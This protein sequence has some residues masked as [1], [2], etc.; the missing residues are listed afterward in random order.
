MS[1]FYRPDDGFVGD[2]IP[3]YWQGQYH[4][5]YLKDPLPPGRYGP[6]HILPWAHLV[7]SDLTQWE[8]WPLVIEPGGPDDPDSVGCYT[9]SV[10]ERNGIYYMFYTGSA[11]RGNPQTTCLATSR[12][13]RVWVK[14]PRNPIFGADPHWYEMIDWRD[15]FPF[16]NE[17]VG[18]YWMLHAAR[19]KSGPSN[20]RGCLALA[21]SPDLENWEV[22]PPF[23]APR[24]YYTHECP[25][26]FRWNDKWVLVY[27][28]FSE[29]HVTHY[30]MSDSLSGP[31]LAPANDTF[32]GRAFYAA[33]TASDG[34]R[35][36]VFG[37]DPTRKG[38]TD[39]GAW[40]WAGNMVIHEVVSGPEGGLAVKLPPEVASL[41]TQPHLIACTPKFGEW[42]VQGGAFVAKQNDGFS[43]CTLADLPDTGLV[44]L[45]L[46][47]QLGTRS[48]GVLLRAETELESYYQVRWEP[49][50]QRIVFDRWPRPGDVPFML[51]RPLPI[52]PATPLRLQILVEGSAIVVYANDV[53]ALS[54]RGYDHVSG[55]LGLFVAEGGAHFDNVSL[56]GAV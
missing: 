17:E 53:V 33:K 28:T 9:G 46:H 50:R 44:A 11:G 26:L 18:E 56:F 7:S 51:E 4:A 31:W 29:R 27:S 48:C 38:E 1:I 37:W 20:R 39:D 45:T 35:R 22:R 47:C 13:L 36:F 24:L 34:R 14:D 2:V 25:D 15:P 40:D 6:E 54:T 42:Q 55:Q 10:I 52:E 43:A 19:V 32:D 3:F 5:F 30:R 8:E 41:F 16:W 49:D 21:A 23:W 12:D